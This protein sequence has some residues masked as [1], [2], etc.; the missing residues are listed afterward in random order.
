MSNQGAT[1]GVV[2]VGPWMEMVVTLA[3]AAGT[4]V[5]VWPGHWEGHRPRGTGVKSI[6]KAIGGPE[7][8]V[9][10]D[11]S[12]LADT[13]LI[14]V[15]LPTWRMRSSSLI[16]GNHIGGYHRLVHLVRGL[17]STSGLRA[18][19]LLTETT[20]VKRIAALAGPLFPGIILAGKLGGGV[21][22][23]KFPSV[24]KEVQ[25]ALASD[26][27]RV[28]G[29]RDLIGVEIAAASAPLIALVSGLAA[30]LELG[31]SVEGMLVAR[32]I[33]EV[34]RLCK[35]FGGQDAT[36][37]GMAG[38]GYVVAQI[39]EG[40][41]SDFAAG[42]RLAQ[43]GKIETLEKDL[44]PGARE[45]IVSSQLLADKARSAGVQAHIITAAASV[46]HGEA[47]VREATHTLMTLTQ[48]ME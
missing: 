31:P 41:G 2:G 14:V 15:A 9:T 33:A 40:A 13:W 30:G 48:M 10:N 4:S 8:T 28:Y 1:L 44:G 16:L 12:V 11:P 32:G 46:L 34:G 23:S 21:V 36:A 26:R 3:R 43:G 17:D 47:S 5:V 37:I 29:N 45:L 20:P 39:A 38:L 25:T 7:V 27:F 24:V 22:G 19:E 35:H 18:S 42:V 6:E